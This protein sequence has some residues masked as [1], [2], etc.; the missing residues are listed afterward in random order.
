M[1]YVPLARDLEHWFDRQLEALPV[2][3]RRRVKLKFFP[4]PW[5]DL[6]S[7]ERRSLARQI[8]YQKDPNTAPHQA[9]WFNF[10]E[11]LSAM[12]GAASLMAATKASNPN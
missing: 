8:D 11:D 10:Y 6:S 5:N 4:A 1:D 12:R 9:Y 7:N 2:P 3:L